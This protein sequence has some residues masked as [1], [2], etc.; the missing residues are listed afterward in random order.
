MGMHDG[1]YSMPTVADVYRSISC[2]FSWLYTEN[3]IVENPMQRVKK[4]KVP[5]EFARTF[6][7]GE[8][9]MMFDFWDKGTF[10]GYRNFLILSLLL[11]TGIRKTELLQL[12]LTDIDFDARVLLVRGKGDKQRFVP[13]SKMMVRLLRNYLMKRKAYLADVNQDSNALFVNRLG[14]RLGKSGLEEIFAKMKKGLKIDKRR[15]SPHTF[16][17]T[18]ARAFLSNGGNLFSL[19]D[20]LGHEDIATTRIYVEFGID[21]NRQQIDSYCP[22]DNRAYG[23]RNKLP[24]PIEEWADYY[25]GAIHLHGHQHNTSAYNLQ[26]KQAGLR[27]FDVGVD[28]NGYAPVSVEGIIAFFEQ[29]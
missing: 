3:M 4:P 1:C 15:L 2:F 12:S 8:V 27:R 9:R 19:Q 6:S 11:G 28:A 14:R 17:H 22:I 26:Q 5:K 20:I 21:G 7:H 13:L 10:Y 25:K 24:Y 18:F 23:S 29:K 16:R